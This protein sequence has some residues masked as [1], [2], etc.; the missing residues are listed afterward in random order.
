MKS[1]NLTIPLDEV[2]GGFTPRVC[3]QGRGERSYPLQEK[4]KEWGRRERKNVVEALPEDG[5]GVKLPGANSEG[6]NDLT[7]VSTTIVPATA[8]TVPTPGHNSVSN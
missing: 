6:I 3:E 2:C 5:M 1:C 7:V 4:K 8:T